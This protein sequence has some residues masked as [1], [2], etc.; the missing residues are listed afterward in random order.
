M[1]VSNSIAARDSEAEFTRELTM[2][3]DAGAGVI[4]VRTTEIPRAIMALRKSI[5]TGGNQYR[6]WNVVDGMRPVSIADI[7]SGYLKGD[8]NSDFTS[9][10]RLISEEAPDESDTERYTFFVFSNPKQWLVEQNAAAVHLVQQYSQTLPATNIRIVLVM[11]DEPIDKSME[12]VV[13]TLRFETPGHQELKEALTSVLGG[14]DKKVLDVDDEGIERICYNSAGMTLASFEMHASLSIVD[15]AVSKGRNSVVDADDILKGLNAAKTG[16]VS[17]NDLLELYPIE[18]MDQVGGMENLKEWVSKRANCYSDDARDFGIEPPK[19]MVY[20][21]PPGTG[22]SLA[23]KAVASVLGIP[24]VRLDF[25]RVF[26]SL[27][28]A[29]E[30]RIR[31]ALKMVE[32]M[33]P[34]VLF[35][36]EIDKGLGGAGGSGDSGTSSRVLGSFLTWLNDNETP[37][38]TMVTANNVTGL[39]PELMRRGRFDA[40]FASGFPT[41]EE[42]LEILK[43]HLNKRGWDPADFDK[44]ELNLVV[45]ASKG[46]V[47][48]EIEAC[49]K[50]GLVDAFAADEDLTPQHMIA[51]LKNMVPLSVAFNETVQEMTLWAKN[52]ATPASKQ[53]DV[54]DHK[55]VADIASSGKR[56]TRITKRDG[57]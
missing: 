14:V 29:S 8:E 31:T 34:C 54:V 24:L 46:Y 55:K 30:E 37:V 18:G 38:F 1:Q 32:N 45:E 56:R 47:G 26:N 9:A 35:C 27:V 11:P 25:G 33:S 49:V 2:L 20:V 57:D 28:G 19:G 10:L 7:S 48:S 5:V 21:G 40:I 44:K 53:Y 42:R 4:H 41:A 43:I 51:A 15:A 12:D 13:A 52:N 39:P 50:D 22:K 23:A 36:D 17:R 16:V 6:E 3:A